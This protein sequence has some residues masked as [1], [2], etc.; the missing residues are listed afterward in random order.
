MFTTLTEITSFQPAD[1]VQGWGHPVDPVGCSPGSAVRLVVN[2]PVAGADALTEKELVEERVGGGCKA[3]GP[4]TVR[5]AADSLEDDVVGNTKSLHASPPEL[6]GEGDTSFESARHECI[7]AFSRVTS[8][9]DLGDI[10]MGR[11][12]G[13]KDLDNAGY[14]LGS[15]HHGR[16]AVTGAADVGEEAFSAAAVIG[17][18][19]NH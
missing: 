7:V 2:R 8:N 5:M 6:D 14:T 17:L 12:S 9:G 3:R 1:L 13:F 10:D 4:S 18:L 19:G 15:C 16:G 11:G